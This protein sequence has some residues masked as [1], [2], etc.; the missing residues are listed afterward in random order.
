MIIASGPHEFLPLA[1][2][3]T[4]RKL[5][6]PQELSHRWPPGIEHEPQEQGRIY[7]GQK[8]EQISKSSLLILH[9]ENVIGAVLDIELRD[10][11]ILNNYRGHHEPIDGGHG[12]HTR[13]VFLQDILIPA[14][15]RIDICDGKRRRELYIRNGGGKSQKIC[16]V[17]LHM[18]FGN[19]TIHEPHHE[20]TTDDRIDPGRQDAPKNWVDVI[21]EPTEGIVKTPE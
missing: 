10:G 5:L 11:K 4:W 21:S 6:S 13:P 12:I 8:Q 3:L 17:R 18:D 2:V 9:I 14:N 1:N 7:R 20:D 19:G 15:G 16:P